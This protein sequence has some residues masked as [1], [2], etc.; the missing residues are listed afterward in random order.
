MFQLGGQPDNIDTK[1]ETTRSEQ[2][3]EAREPARSGPSV[4]PTRLTPTAVLTWLSV[5]EQ[6]LPVN[7]KNLSQVRE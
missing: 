7:E 4:K 6:A 5:N 2:T 3:A 1:N